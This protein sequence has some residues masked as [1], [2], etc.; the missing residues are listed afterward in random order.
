[1]DKFTYSDQKSGVSFEVY[2][3]ESKCTELNNLLGTFKFPDIPPTPKGEAHYFSV[4]F[5]IDANGI[6][7]VS[8]MKTTEQK[9]DI[10]FTTSHRGKT[11]RIKLRG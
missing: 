3:G 7:N 9:I 2:E 5:E 10:A 6:L 11:E 8:A 4:F 1:M